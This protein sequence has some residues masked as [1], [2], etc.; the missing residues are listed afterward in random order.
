MTVSAEASEPPAAVRSSLTLVGGPD[1]LSREIANALTRLDPHV[2]LIEGPIA[3]SDVSDDTH[4]IYLAEVRSHHGVAPDLADAE[5]TI[6]LAARKA[7]RL[8][9]LSSSAVFPPHH[10]N[11]GMMSEDVRPE[12]DRD[13]LADRW[14]TLETM[15]REGCLERQTLLTI[16]R[17]PPP[18]A[19]GAPNYFSRLFA[20]RVAFVLAGHDP[21]MQ[22]ISAASLAEGLRRLIVAETHG[23]FHL[24]PSG[25]IPLRQALKRAGVCRV[26]LPRWLLWGARALGR[27]FGASPP[28]QLPQLRYCWTIDGPRF[29]AE[30][31]WAAPEASADAVAAAKPR[32]AARLSPPPAYDNF[33]MDPDAIAF[34]N[35]TLLRF[36]HDFYWRVETA[37]LEH[38]P[39]NGAAVLTGVH[40]GFMPFDATMV[41]HRLTRELGRC[42][43]FLI[44]P[45]L[46]KQPFLADFI[47]KLGGVVACQENA[48]RI[49]GQGELL[50]VYP[51]GIRGAFRMYKDAYTLGKFGRDEYVKMSL[52]WR[53]PIVPFVTLGSAE[54]F[55]ILG[56]IDWRWWRRVS[57]WPFLPLTPTFP[58]LPLPLPAKMH[59]L[60]LEPVRPYEDHPPEAADDRTVVR[61]ISAAIKARLLAALQDLRA[62]RKHIFFGSVFKKETAIPR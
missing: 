53:A 22:F 9:L 50:G 28:A 48:D 31:G 52:R 59:T 16:L 29:A 36:L 6:E 38:V 54:T 25:A 23:L 8:T 26:P 32:R 2:R 35:R 21:T 15:A 17:T 57:E 34:Y 20:A 24:T 58:L 12:P 11:R 46:I 19:A 41:L 13:P 33:G 7:A 37:G 44:H 30:L 51:E 1:P 39:R 62:R 10:W 42:P 47:T 55:P 45:C 43:R 18:I 14:Q 4:L 60:F 40:R 3:G 49:L 56:K 5:M 27:L 61:E